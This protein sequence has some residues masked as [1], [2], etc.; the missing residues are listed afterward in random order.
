[1][2][3]NVHVVLQKYSDGE[4]GEDKDSA[5]SDM[6][7]SPSVPLFQNLLLNFLDNKAPVLGES[8]SG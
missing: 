7:I 2:S 8:Q 4:M 6:F 5:G 1:V 3:T